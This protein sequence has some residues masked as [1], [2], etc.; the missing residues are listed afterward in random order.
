MSREAADVTE[1]I[2][3][4]FRPCDAR[5]DT[6]LFRLMRLMRRFIGLLT[7][8][9]LCGCGGD[10][11]TND[12]GV[13]WTPGDCRVHEPAS[14]C[15][16]PTCLHASDSIKCSTIGYSCSY[17]EYG[18][19]C[20]EDGTWHCRSGFKDMSIYTDISTTDDMS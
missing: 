12:A 6:R 4:S 2:P 18:C 15:C 16:D 14:G 8:A 3:G 10:S 9:L 13:C 7:V 20:D 1:G 17:F 5:C 11:A 19:V